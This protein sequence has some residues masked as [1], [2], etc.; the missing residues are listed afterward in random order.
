MAAGLSF[1]LLACRLT[2]YADGIVRF[3]DRASN[4]FRG[5]L[6]FVLPEAIFRPRLARG[7]SGLADAPRPFVLQAKEL[8]GQTVARSSFGCDLNLFAPTLE[9][10]FKRAFETLAERGITPSR[11]PLRLEKWDSRRVLI[12]LADVEPVTRL[13]VHFETPTEL[14]GWDGNG[15]PPFEILACRLRDRLSALRSLYGQAEPAQSPSPV[16]RTSV[17]EGLQPAPSSDQS[18][19]AE[20]GSQ[21]SST[22]TPATANVESGSQPIV[23]RGPGPLEIDFKAFG[24]R[25]TRV[26]AT[27]GE[28]AHETA[29]RTSSRTG[30]SHPLGGVTGWVEYEGELGEFLPYLRA[31][32]YMGVGRQTVWGHGRLKVEI[33]G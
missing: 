32:A 5:A 2:F 20:S 26:A 24:E 29:R 1:E 22:P 10:Q 7:P 28:L 3:P 33:L 13:R 14:K 6:G 9:A 15:W 25:A 30:M 16:G 4:T 27:A 8:D 19:N 31:A 23:F 21:P 12:R 18:A 11:T 17:C